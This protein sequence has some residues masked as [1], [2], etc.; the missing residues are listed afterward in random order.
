MLTASTAMPL[1]QEMNEKFALTTQLFLKE[2]KKK[3]EQP[4]T[5]PRQI[6]GLKLSEKMMKQKPQRLIASPDTVGGV[7]Y[8]SCFIHLK[9]VND[10]SAVRSLGVEVE[11]T[12]DGLDF[13][14]ARVPVKK[15]EKLAD[16]DNV[17]R[18][19]VA[20]RMR[21]MTDV[22]RQKT[23]VDDLLKLSTD[24]TAVGINTK[25]DGTGVV[26]GIIDTGIDFQHI[27]FKDKN[28][29][30]RIKCAYVYDGASAREYT[31]IT[32]SSP[33]TDDNAQDHGTHTAS[34]AGG[35]SV[36]VSGSTVSVTND[37]ANATYGGMAPGA[38]LYLAGIKNLYGNELANA[39]KK[40]VTYADA[41]GKPLVVSNSWGS[42]YGP[43][44]GTGELADLVGQYFGDSHPNRVIFFSSS[45]DAESVSKDNEG[46]GFFVKKSSASSGSPLGTILRSNTYSNTDAGFYYPDD[47]SLA[48]STKK[49]NC[50]IHV[51][52]SS[53]GAVIK[54]WTVT[55]STTS[56]SGLDTYYDGTLDVIISSW[57]D[58]KYYIYV[59]TDDG[60]ETKG[61][62][63]TTKN[64]KDY[65]KSAYTLAIEVYPASGSANVDMWATGRGNG[66]SSYF[67][68]HL[69]TT[70]HTWI[71]GTY[72][73]CVS[74]NATIP[75]A[76]S[77]GAYVSK[78]DWRESSGS[79]YSSSDIY[80]MGDIAYFSS[81]ATAA[82]SPTGQA[83]PWI[84]AP[85]ARVAAGVN[86]YHT[87]SVDDYSYYGSKLKSDLVV[88]NGNYPYA[89]MEGTSMAT[90][91]AAGIVAL[92][93]QAA[94]SV[95][96]D[97]TVNDVKE[98]MKQTA[99]HDQYTNGTNASHFGNGKIDALAGI[100]YILGM[101]ESINNI[102][103][104]GIYYSL[105]TDNKTAEVISN[106]N[107]YSG[108]VNIPESVTYNSKTYKVTSIGDRAFYGCSGL[109][110]IVIPNT[111]TCI[112]DRAFSLCS[113]LTSVN[114]P[115]GV[116]SIGFCA[117]SFCTSLISVNIPNSVT[118]IGES[119]FDQ[120]WDMISVTIGS[121]VVSIGADSFKS[122]RSLTSITI[123]ES[124]NSIGEK[125]FSG[126]YNLTDVYCYAENVPSTDNSA[127]SNSDIESVTLH[128]PTG[129]INS[130]KAT[131][132]WSEFGTIV[133][134]E[135]ENTNIQFDDDNIKAICVANWDTNKDGELSKAE[136][137]KV[138]SLGEVFK[139]NKTITSFN[140]LQYFTSLTSIGANAFDGCSGLTSVTIGNGVTT[141]EYCAFGG[142]SG[143]TS[144]TIPE[145][146]KGIGNVAFSGCSG[147]T[148]VTIRGSVTSIGGWAFEGCSGLKKVI[149]PDIAAWCG[150]S[151]SYNGN[152]LSYAHHLYSDEETE[153]TDLIIPNSVTRISSRAFEG[154]SGLTSVTIPNSVTS[155]EIQAFQ[156]CT[157]LTS[158]TIPNSVTSILNYA[159][160]GCSGLISVT[161]PNSVTRIYKSAF[162]DCANLTSIMVDA[163]NTKYDSRND[164]NAIIET[165]TNT[166]IAGCKNTTIPNSV[167]SIGESAFEG[168]SGMTSITIP[169]SV[170]SIGDHAFSGCSGLTSITIPNSVTTIGESAFHNCS[171]LTSIFIGNG[172]TSIGY[173][174][175]RYCSDL[176]DVYCLAEIVPNTNLDA[177]SNSP[178]ASATLHV[179]A[180]ALDAY[181]ATEP[182][183]KFGTIVAIDEPGLEVTD[184]SLLDN[185]IYIEPTIGLAGS[186]ID[187]CVKMKNTLTS[188]G[189]SFMLKLPEGLRLQKDEDGDVVYQMGNRAKKMSL[190]MK[191]WDNG[192]Y[193]FAL[194][195]S[196]GTATISG[197]DDVVVTFKLP[198]PDNMAA[199]VYKL[200]LTK[201]LI[202]SKING[203]TT[204]TALSDVVT[205][206]TVE[207]YILG[208]ANGDGNVTPSD[209]IMTLYHYF[210]VEQTGFNVKAA[211]V[212]G[213]GNVTPADA[214]ETLYIYFN[215]GS[216]SNARRT[217]QILDPQ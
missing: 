149:V 183:S 95:G 191:D 75:D 143:L 165:A 10:L 161:I 174:A 70:G 115:N 215:A 112:D 68:N 132:P 72:D 64:G 184:I 133:A 8:I 16:I 208:D 65:Y 83:Y 118:S 151:F 18:I 82:Q 101:D 205:T 32:S 206:L 194:T 54:S 140:E 203:T 209:A 129:S 125:A 79:S 61:W 24:A 107:K 15:L 214:I 67:T 14:T 23:N 173:A 11:E 179:P 17:T 34:T 5:K 181:K 166:L 137:A 87:S 38:D 122:C 200:E 26:L 49:L 120:C 150:I 195:P 1:A 152:P 76:I 51:L 207:D 153:I 121:G 164:C 109:T 53:T 85:G 110:S 9:E 59:S 167:T 13:V 126:C 22:A 31:T 177:F 202:Q 155:I 36:I 212:N 6:P 144:V 163:G 134:I 55:S 19:K 117:F 136:A 187:L 198:I 21:P 154:C 35:S 77:V 44:D 20:E 190:N 180:S 103:I 3:A 98:I 145:S 127:F 204:D 90:P 148:S 159:F 111:V 33:T 37:H 119:A 25:Y 156:A 12:F 80:T 157:G 94:K 58:E 197:N 185:A 106:P 84:T 114:I 4:T 62:T 99:I 170:T 91:V 108:D 42:Q 128:V 30:S 63:T 50:K 217:Q 172:V 81:Y 123:P 211:D 186:T 2:Q 147:L 89:M 169:N 29:N 43:H 52:N 189:C 39:L 196:T 168:H 116:I 102:E 74:N 193:D 88:N 105:D 78:T 97:L 213:D 192:S 199:D 188:V 216:Q 142:C 46:G 66:T 139:S 7:A 45:N 171:G 124:V 201:C 158:V 57:N 60:L 69:T 138:T 92:W 71:A 178:I 113:G 175:F 162:A 48:F 135:V 93:L 131:S 73:M 182:W 146:V 96:K 141:I 160:D 41:Q 100:Q 28:G 130:Y 176:T 27:A 40:M 86:H 56:F 104:N 47:I 210:N